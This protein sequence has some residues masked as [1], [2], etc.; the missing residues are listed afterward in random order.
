MANPN[1]IN[2][3][4]VLGKVATQAVG[5][6]YTAIVTAATDTIVKINSLHIT[7]I[8]SS[9]L[10]GAISARINKSVGTDARIADEIVVPDAS[11]LVLIS[12]DSSIYLEEGDSLE[13]LANSTSYL[14]ATCSYEIIS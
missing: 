11:T 10:N 9:D 7:N 14:E 8:N 1:I 6:S 3:S 2:V 4:S 12:K 13:L 5:A